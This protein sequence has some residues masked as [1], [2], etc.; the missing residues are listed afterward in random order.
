MAVGATYFT[1]LNLLQHRI[2]LVCPTQHPRYTERLVIRV[3]V[4]EVKGAMISLPA[5]NTRVQVQIRG[6]LGSGICENPGTAALGSR[7]V[8][9][10]TV[11]VLDP[12]AGSD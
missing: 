4:I 5:V 9:A 11:Q 2:P 3:S 1:L 8:T 7:K 6:E 12:V 10:L